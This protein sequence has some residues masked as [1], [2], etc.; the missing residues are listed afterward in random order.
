MKIDIYSRADMAGKVKYADISE[1]YL[2]NNFIS[3]VTKYDEQVFGT[4]CPHNVIRD[5]VLI[6]ELSPEIITKLEIYGDIEF[7]TH[8]SSIKK[9]AKKLIE[10]L[11]S[12]DRTKPLQINCGGGNSRSGTTAWCINEFINKNK[13]ETDYNY[14]KNTYNFIKFS[15]MIKTVLMYEFEKKLIV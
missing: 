9:S 8:I 6:I 4:R 15:P 1:F 14:F 13:N 5:N 7:K 10:F 12:I 11:N 3:I 2:N